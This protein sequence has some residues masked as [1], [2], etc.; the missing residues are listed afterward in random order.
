[1][2]QST[3]EM[4]IAFPI[5]S[6]SLILGKQS[7][8]VNEWK[9]NTFFTAHK[10]ISDINNTVTFYLDPEIKSEMMGHIVEDTGVLATNPVKTTASQVRNFYIWSGLDL[11]KL[12]F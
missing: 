10:L 9:F 4:L 7:I 12:L 3:N 5:D 8:N 2:S 11:S 6:T 1:M